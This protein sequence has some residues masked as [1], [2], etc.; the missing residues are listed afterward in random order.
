MRDCAR[1][2]LPAGTSAVPQIIDEHR[3]VRGVGLPAIDPDQAIFSAK[4]LLVGD[5]EGQSLM[6]KPMRDKAEVAV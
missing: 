3:I 4:R 5:L 2:G 6:T 1:D